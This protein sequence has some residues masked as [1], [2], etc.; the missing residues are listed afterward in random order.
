MQDEI[1]ILTPVGMLGYGF[2]LELFWSAVHNG[3]DAIVADSGSTDSGPSKLATGALT[4]KRLAYEKDLGPMVAACHYYKVPILIG[5]AGGDGAN[6]R[7]PLFLEIISEIIAKNGYRPMKVLTIE[8]EIDKELVYAGLERGVIRP[9]GGAVPPLQK[10][11]VDAASR[12]VAQM[13]HEPYVK[14]MQDH[15]D[16]DIIIG[17]RS[18]DPAPYA[19]FCIHKGIKDLGI[20]YHMGKIME[21]G[22]LCATPKSREAMAVVRQDSFDLWPLAPEARCTKVS[23]AGHTLYEKSR[24][25]FLAGPGGQLDLNGATYEELPDGRTVRCRGAVFRPTPYTIKLEGAKVSGFQTSFIGGVSDPILI[26][27]IDDFLDKGRAML[28]HAVDFPCD[29]KFHVY[30]RTDGAPFAKEIGVSGVVWAD[31]QERANHV[32][33]LARVYLLHASYT[34]QLATGGNL[35]IPIMPFG[36]PLGPLS[37]FCVYH[38][39]PVD[40]PTSLFPIKAQ[41]LDGPDTAGSTSPALTNGYKDGSGLKPPRVDQ[42]RADAVVK[43]ALQPPPKRGHVYL[44]SLARIVRSK[45]SGPYEITMDVML[46]TQEAYDRV[47]KAGVLTREKV[48]EMYGVRDEDVLVCMW[49]EPALAWKATLKRESSKPSGSF[50]EVD[51]YACQMHVPLLYLEVPEGDKET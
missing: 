45:N 29:L 26:S 11:D 51:M 43:A 16:F 3:V 9:C 15:P 46:P 14:A 10:E 1:K 30:G 27:Q 18:Y 32:A 25:D 4:V 39:L 2:S 23:V 33:S 44:A 22:A 13:G 12:L 19:A 35:T 50:G 41:T 38:L 49:W 5:S 31:T 8:A 6:S 47:Q 20:A 17:G 42:S 37:E 21:C 28:T 7:L 36:Q 34:G 24:P 48:I 40:D